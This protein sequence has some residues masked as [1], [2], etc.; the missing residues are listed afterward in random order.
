MSMVISAV[1]TIMAFLVIELT[2]GSAVNLD[3]W[4]LV[5]MLFAILLELER[6][7]RR[8]DDLQR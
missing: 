4:L 1:T 7:R 8:L 2:G 3:T 6:I 5:M